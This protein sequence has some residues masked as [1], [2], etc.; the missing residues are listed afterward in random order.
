MYS[1]KSSINLNYKLNLSNDTN[2]D[3]NYDINNDTNDIYKN[4]LQLN[5]ELN[6]VKNKINKYYE[7]NCILWDKLKKFSNEYE[8]IYSSSCNSYKNISTIYPISRS[9]F[10]LWE[11]I[12]DFKYLINFNNNESFKSAHIAEGPGGFI[13]CIY[14]YINSYFD[15]NIFPKV[16]IF[17]L[18][19]L[20]DNSN[21]PNWKIKK[22]IINTFDIELNNKEQCDGN[23]YSLSNINI[24]LKNIGE[25]SCNLITC[26]GGFDF[27][28]NYNEQEENFI[29]FF[30]SEIYMILKLLKNGG[31]SIIKIYDIYSKNSIKLIYILSLF[32]NNIYILKPFTSRPANSE[33]YI[34][35]NHY[36][37]NNDDIKLSNI[38][39]NLKKIIIEKKLELL[40]NDNISIPYNFLKE[41]YNYN[42]WYTNRQIKYI[43]KTIDL[44]ETTTN[45]NKN[46]LLADIYNSNKKKCIEWCKNYNIKYRE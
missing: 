2:D 34:L 9:Y 31:N 18:T 21:I 40:E 41:I 28:Y 1:Y 26:D 36:N 5:E 35:C 20:S 11:I 22:N 17:G 39:E 3:T 32:F 37:N 25:N 42:K 15:K 10:K 19:L 8:F 14:K 23:L 33:K 6:N 16:K 38:I 24:F 44:I 12:H 27:S 43:N 4:I 45:E 7:N 13:E 46:D 30:I 29:F